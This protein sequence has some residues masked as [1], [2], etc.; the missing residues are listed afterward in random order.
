MTGHLYITLKIYLD[1]VLAY[2]TSE[3]EFMA[4]L[5]PTLER[6]TEYN[7]SLSMVDFLGHTLDD[8]GVH[9]FCRETGDSNEH[10]APYLAETDEIVSR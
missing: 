4:N 6:M 7:L 3:V 9:Y 5:E 1:N 10:T 2:G 8:T